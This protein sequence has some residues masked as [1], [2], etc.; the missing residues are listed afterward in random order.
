LFETN[1]E[2]DLMPSSY[3]IRGIDERSTASVEAQSAELW[4]PNLVDI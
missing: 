4:C 3:R 2:E 1:P